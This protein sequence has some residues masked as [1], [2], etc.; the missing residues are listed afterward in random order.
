MVLWHKAQN[1]MYSVDCE[2]DIGQ[3]GKLWPTE[4]AAWD[5]AKKLYE[6]QDSFAGPFEE[7]KDDGLIGVTKHEVQ[8]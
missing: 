2:W 8:D 1:L 4:E 7:V 5:G 6:D 3:E